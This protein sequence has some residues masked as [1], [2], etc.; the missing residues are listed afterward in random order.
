MRILATATAVPPYVLP[1]KTYRELVSR[2]FPR[3]E[4]RTAMTVAD[5]ARVVERHLA[6]TPEEALTPRPLGETSRRYAEVA[7][8]L[9][10][11]VARQALDRA[12][13]LPTE[14]DLLVTA[15]CTGVMLPSVD[16]FLVERLGMR[17]DCVRLPITELG[18][19][20]GA[21]ALG[22][23][24]EHLLAHPDHM[25]L[26][27]ACELCSLTFQPGDTSQTNAVAASL[28]GDGAAACIVGPSS[29]AR[30]PSPR[31]VA[32]RTHLFPQSHHLM[33]FRLESTGLHIILDREVPFAL[34]GKVRPLVEDVLRDEGIALED[35]RFAV[36]HPGGRRILEDLG[37]DLGCEELL[38]PSWDV[39]ARVGN[40]SSAT[41]LFVLDEVM[42]STAP[43]PPGAPGLLL[44]F[45]PGFSAEVGVLRWEGDGKV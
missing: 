7:T 38:Q 16:A 41:V 35:L 26:V 25:V 27:V 40:L 39:L 33:G 9:C 6:I 34:D 1:Q 20:A 37:R 19:A 31:L 21:A 22:R 36:V 45:G 23:A 2:A 43:P 11:R 4:A 44:A 32:H 24:R 12:A 30:R 14:I 18:C 10:E 3:R 8:D 15:S 28:F 5:H 13:V 42:R 29:R 17:R